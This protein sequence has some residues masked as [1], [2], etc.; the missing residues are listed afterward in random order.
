MIPSLFFSRLKVIISDIEQDSGV[1]L[2]KDVKVVI[3][4]DKAMLRKLN[5]PSALIVVSGF[6]SDAEHPQI[7]N[8]AFSV[9]P[10]VVNKHD[11]F[12]EC[13]LTGSG[14]TK[15]LHYVSKKVHAAITGLQ[16][17]AGSINI[18][19]GNHGGIIHEKG[20]TAISHREFRCDVLL[21]AE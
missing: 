12:G 16:S 20:A 3:G 11:I 15:G 21:D 14:N 1:K 6:L 7:G 5:F 9:M 2:F 19:E 8:Q 18:V 4:Y 13:I 17:L 10:F